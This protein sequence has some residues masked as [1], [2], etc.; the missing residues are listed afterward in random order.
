MAGYSSSP[1]FPVTANAIQSTLEGTQ[2]TII[3]KLDPTGSAL[4]Y[5][6]YLGGSSGSEEGAYG[7]ALDCNANAYV[8][9]STAST[10]FPLSSGAYQTTYGGGAYDCYT[11]K[12]AIGTPVVSAVSPSS[13]PLTGGT[14]VTITGINFSNA[15][16]VLFGSTAALTFSVDSDTQ[17]TVVSPPHDLGIVDIT[18]TGIGV[19]SPSSADLFTYQ[20]IATTTTL[21][22]SPNPVK[23]G[24]S[25]ILKGTVS[26][27]SS[28]TGSM[29]FFDGEKLLGVVRLL[30]GSAALNTDTLSPGKHHIIAT[31]SGDNRYRGSLSEISTLHVKPAKV[32]R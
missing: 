15:T 7:I 2:S 17:I 25:V 19:S 22:A 11:A 21:N 23:A 6:T 28:A 26:S 12:L 8:A 20:L 24:Q 1:N 32:R 14:A 3:S 9:G 27:S 13:G 4:T 10:A 29:T 30:N 18:V 31:Y 5:S 16:A